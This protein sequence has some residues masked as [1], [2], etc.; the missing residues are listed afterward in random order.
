[1]RLGGSITGEHG[2]GLEKRDYLPEMYGADDLDAMR[3]VRLAFDPREISNRGKML[4]FEA[5]TA[6]A[7]R[8]FSGQHPLERAGVIQRE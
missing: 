7:P 2:V 4:A 6:A 5:D 3:R 1:M 8:A